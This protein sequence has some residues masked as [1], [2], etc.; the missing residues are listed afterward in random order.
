LVHE[1]V[2]VRSLPTM[3]EIFTRAFELRRITRAVW[4]PIERAQFTIR[5]GVHSR[6]A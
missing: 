3:V 6:C 5:N 1:L 4:G 2:E